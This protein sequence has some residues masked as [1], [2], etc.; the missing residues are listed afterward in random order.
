MTDPDTQL[1]ASVINRLGA[2]ELTDVLKVIFE[3]LE[4]VESEIFPP[5]EA[6][7]PAV[8]AEAGGQEAAETVP[9][10]EEGTPQAPVEETSSSDPSES[11]PP[12]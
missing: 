11:A 7:T 10:T 8:A 9:Q 5:A 1:V 4:K 2:H 6:E 12:A 3:R